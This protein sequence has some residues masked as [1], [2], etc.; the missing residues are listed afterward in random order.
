M[1]SPD[2]SLVVGSGSK[3][4]TGL[5]GLPQELKNQI[6][7]YL[8]GEC[9]CIHHDDWYCHF[10]Y[11]TASELSRHALFQTSKSVRN[12]AMEICFSKV[13]FCW[14][15]QG[16]YCWDD[17]CRTLSFSANGLL[18]HLPIDRLMNISLAFD[19]SENFWRKGDSRGDSR[20]WCL[21]DSSV[22]CDLFKIF[23]GAETLRKKMR[24]KFTDCSKS[25]HRIIPTKYFQGLTAMTGFQSV[26][27][28][29]SITQHPWEYDDDDKGKL[30]DCEH[31]QT[32]MKDVLE[33][34]LGP[35]IIGTPKL[36]KWGWFD[37]FS[38]LEFRPR[39]QSTRL[40]GNET[41]GAAGY[42]HR[43]LCGFRTDAEPPKQMKTEVTRPRHRPSS[44]AETEA[45]K[46]H[47]AMTRTQNS[48]QSCRV[49][50]SIEQD[51]DEETK[52]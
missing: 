45:S 50:Q 5:A 11:P 17:S 49:A 39:Q 22:R 47:Q 41:A 43:D 40:L 33:P 16:D 38:F 32:A 8:I 13:E 31:L 6:Y 24:I 25:T 14:D 29:I 46:L 23:G 18:D 12:D 44:R 26:V 35:A 1:T 10:I 7:G 30:S 37:G 52:M 20:W 36:D 19:M 15:V 9:N 4:K 2:T 42:R 51:L 3:S 34:A 28:E 48:M 27:V 21:E